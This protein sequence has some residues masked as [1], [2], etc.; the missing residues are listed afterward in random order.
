[1]S[2]AFSNT[3]LKC[4][5]QFIPFFNG[6]HHCRICGLLFCND[7]CGDFLY[8]QLKKVNP[9]K[10]PSEACNNAP[11][12]TCKNCYAE[13]KRTSLVKTTPYDLV[14]KPELKKKEECPVCGNEISK[15]GHGTIEEC[16]LRTEENYKKK[17][18]VNNRML[19]YQMTEEEIHT[20][21]ASS[22]EDFD[23]PICFEDFE[24]DVKV[25]RL[26]CLCLYHYSCI[27][28]WFEK[29]KSKVKNTDNILPPTI[30][31]NWCPV[32]DALS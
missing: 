23:C 21:K 24:K 10:N 19:V 31:R 1:M 11:Y 16:L 5:S 26:E 9:L 29:K 27:K 12:R 25:G 15:Q 28:S 7:C 14:R 13:L 4:N 6:K 8:Y 22:D 20:H 2:D 17:T 18:N 30:S 3:C 32:H